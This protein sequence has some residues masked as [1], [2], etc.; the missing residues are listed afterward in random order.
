VTTVVTLVATQIVDAGQDTD[1]TVYVLTEDNSSLRL[2]V[3]VG[4]D[5]SEQFEAGTGK[6]ND[7]T[8]QFWTF[9]YNAVDGTQVTVEVQ[10]DAAGLRMGVAKGPI[11]GKGFT[12]GQTGSVLTPIAPAT[13]AALQA[14][15]TETFHVEYLGSST[16]QTVVVISSDHDSAANL[17]LFLGPLSSLYQRAI[18]ANERGLSIPTR[19]ILDFVMVEAGP[20]DDQAAL[21]YESDSPDATITVGAQ[22]PIAFHAPTEPG[23]PAGAMFLCSIG[24]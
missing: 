5:L 19:T 4:A 13:A 3:G 9:Q 11:S 1:G 21:N 15:S 14:T 16:D 23:V 2:F 10:K 22:T 7:G 18:L 17:R 12:V 6:G 8:T 20:A 24:G